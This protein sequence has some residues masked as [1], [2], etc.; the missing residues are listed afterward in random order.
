MT[1]SDLEL[2][3]AT[4]IAYLDL[5]LA[6]DYTNNIENTG[7]L[8]V[9]DAINIILQEHINNLSQAEIDQYEG[10]LDDFKKLKELKENE[11]QNFKPWSIADI[12]N[13]NGPGQTGFYGIVIDTGDG[14]IVSFRGSEDILDLQHVKQDWVNAD[15]A[16]VNSTLTK[17]QQKVNEFLAE[18]NESDYVTKYDNIAFTGHSLGGNL[19]VHGTIMS[20]FYE[21][22]FPRVRQSVNFDGP[23]FSKEYFEHYKEQIDVMN[24]VLGDNFRHYQWS[25]V[26]S[27]LEP[28]PGINCE[29]LATKKKDGIFD[30]IIDFAIMEHSTENLKFDPSGKAYRGEKSKYEFTVGK[31]TEFVDTLPEKLGNVLVDV[32]GGVLIVSAWVSDN[33][34]VKAALIGGVALGVTTFLIVAGPQ[35]IFSATLALAGS[36]TLAVAA[37]YLLVTRGADMEVFIETVLEL[38][39]EIGKGFGNALKWTNDK[40]NQ[41]IDFMSTKVS[42]IR[43]WFNHVMKS[44]GYAVATPVIEVNTD[45]LRHYAER[46]ENVRKRLQ[47][48]D[49]DMNSLYFTNGFLDLLDIIRA[50]RLPNSMKLK[51]CINYLEDTAEAFE[52]AERNIMEQV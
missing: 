51:F 13:D 27:I 21:N 1:Y 30:K 16:L 40:I 6:Q 46:L 3:L 32:F 11:G 22:I 18:I 50:N 41:L 20:T 25:V 15:L 8:M 37:I 24:Q 38:A 49:G 23:G 36:I 28:V 17:Q 7:S 26:G 34:L 33:K 19:S 29:T 45:K 39:K 52:K 44:Y 48:L 31:F 5:H 35:A 9:E 43:D 14:H 4:E 2:R 12:Q 10:V 42:Q 47:N